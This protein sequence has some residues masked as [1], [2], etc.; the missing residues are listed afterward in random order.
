MAHHRARFTALGRWEVA[1]HVIQEGET[2]ARA[3]A[4]GERVDVDRLGMGAPLAGRLT[5]G[6]GVVGVPGGALQPPA[7][8]PRPGQR[9]GGR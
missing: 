3:A 2:F 1:R 6:P 8:L 7:P 9:R 5:R 4:L